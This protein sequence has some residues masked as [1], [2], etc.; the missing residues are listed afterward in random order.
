[1]PPRRLNRHVHA[2]CTKPVPSGC[3]PILNWLRPRLPTSAINSYWIVTSP[4]PGSLL[5][6]TAPLRR[7][8][9]LCKPAVNSASAPSSAK[10][11]ARQTPSYPTKSA[12]SHLFLV[13]LDAESRVQPAMPDAPP[14]ESEV[15]APVTLLTDQFSQ[16]HEA[17]LYS[18]PLLCLVA[19]VIPPCTTL[20]IHPYG[21][22]KR[23]RQY[24]LR[25]LCRFPLLRRPPNHPTSIPNPLP[26]NVSFFGSAPPFGL[27]L[28]RLW[29]H[30]R[31]AFLG[32]IGAC[33][34]RF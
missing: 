29:S 19:A 2:S 6:L 33:A 20:Q 1:M 30:H 31:F 27:A 13:S 7:M 34:E 22:N 18:C 21:L 12:L 8:Q 28:E 11:P 26:T 32:K 16:R 15:A 3:F 4:L 9:A 25:F 10:P 5:N 14:S 24:P 17:F 23:Q